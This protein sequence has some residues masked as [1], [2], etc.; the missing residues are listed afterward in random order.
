[1]FIKNLFASNSDFYVLDFPL[2]KFRMQNYNFFLN[3]KAFLGEI[4]ANI[5]IS[6]VDIVK[7]ACIFLVISQ[8]FSV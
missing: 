7:Y 5:H 6:P 4:S 2:H 3:I 1:M 8:L